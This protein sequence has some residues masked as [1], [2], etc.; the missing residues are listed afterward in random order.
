MP[1]CPQSPDNVEFHPVTA[2][3]WSDL[4]ALFDRRGAQSSCWCMWWRLPR[5]QWLE[6][7]GEGNRAA[8]H[9]LVYSGHVP[10]ILAYSDGRP[11]GWCSVAP[12]DCFGT[13]N[14]SRTLKRIDDRPVWSIV[15][16]YVAPDFRRQGLVSGLIRA[17]VDYV[18]AQGGSIVEA[19]PLVPAKRDA[20]SSYMGVTS[21]FIDAGF[22]EVARTSKSRTIVRRYL[23]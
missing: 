10:G 19:Y 3:R 22:V 17:A 6:Q 15:C 13:L 1:P 5:R 9:R 8:M 23:D 7:Q 14:R 21:T 2:D 18:R 4:E 12:R 11:A 16:F 20:A